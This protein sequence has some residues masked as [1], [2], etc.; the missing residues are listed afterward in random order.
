M[1]EV[2]KKGDLLIFANVEQ[3]ALANVQL[4]K[5]KP[6]EKPLRLDNLSVL[7]LAVKRRAE[8]KVDASQLNVVS[9]VV[10][11][12]ADLRFLKTLKEQA[13]VVEE[14]KRIEHDLENGGPALLQKTNF[15][16]YDVSMLYRLIK[17]DQ[18]VDNLQG[19]FEC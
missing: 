11:K 7:E 14:A 12:I 19:N 10:K 6:V 17:Q 9:D 2:R 15:P 5:A 13:Q 16:S 1:C 3:V 18:E 8:K 4:Q